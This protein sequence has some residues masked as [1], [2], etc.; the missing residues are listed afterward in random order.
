MRHGRHLYGF[1]A[2]YGPKTIQEEQF[3]N[4]VSVVSSGGPKHTALTLP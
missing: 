2:P 1:G 3:F 4:N